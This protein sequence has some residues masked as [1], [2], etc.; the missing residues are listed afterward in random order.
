MSRIIVKNLGKK[1]N[2]SDLKKHFSSK[3]EITDVKVMRKPDGTSRL[4]AFVG[5]RTDEQ[6]LEA[7]KFFDNT[8]IGLSKIT[9]NLAKK[10][11]DTELEE[12]KKVHEKK[13][14]EKLKSIQEKLKRH[15]QEALENSN[16]DYKKKN[17]ISNQKEISTKKAEFLELAVNSSKNKKT[18]ANDDLTATMG[19]EETGK[20]LNKKK[21]SDSDSDSDDYDSDSEDDNVMDEVKDEEDEEEKLKKEKKL[22][23]LDYLRSRMSSQYA[24]SDSDSD[25]ENEKNDNNSDSDSS[26]S[27]NKNNA[28]AFSEKSESEE[29]EDIEEEEKKNNPEEEEVDYSRLYVKNL[30]YS[31][32]EDELRDLCEKFGKVNDVHIPLDNDKRCKGFGYVSFLFPKDS[33]KALRELN[34]GP[35]QGRLLKVSFSKAISQVDKYLINDPAYQKMSSFQKKK[36]EERRKSATNMI[37]ANASYI[38]SDT[39]I[40]SIAEKY[41]VSKSDIMDTSISGGDMAIRMAIAET[42]L[43][44]ENKKFLHSHGINIDILESTHSVDAKKN[45]AVKRSTTLLLIKNLPPES[46]IDELENMFSKFGILD[47]ALISPSKTLAVVEFLE[48]ADAR[49]ALKGLAYKRYKNSP[50]YV[51]FA[52]IDPNIDESKKNKNKGVEDDKKKTKETEKKQTEKKQ[53]DLPNNKEENKAVVEDNMEDY[54]T[55]FVKNLNFKSTEEDLKN[56]L[57]KNGVSQDSLRTILIQ[58]KEKNG[59]LLSQGY[60]FIEFKSFNLAQE[61]LKKLSNTVLDEKVLDFKPSDK[62]L[63]IAPNSLINNELKNHKGKNGKLLVKNIAFQANLNELKKLFSNFGVIK[64]IKLPKKMGADGSSHRGFAFVEFGTN[65]EAANAMASL[66]NTHLYGRHLV[67]E[68]AKEDEENV[69]LASNDTQLGGAGLTDSRKRAQADAEILNVLAKKKGKVADQN[70]LSEGTLGGLGDF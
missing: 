59:V 22:S 9:V 23:D 61:S 62:R 68:W 43:I 25:E 20:L 53:T 6:A 38:R 45:L 49:S 58:K 69:L 31:C 12:S 40:E 5:F 13:S 11:N 2:E 15:E 66:K 54:S 4:F 36:E 34:G 51:E 21:R 67:I 37:N 7:I 17:D 28:D 65:Q 56:H 10:L 41:G 55:L 39:V 26:D 8:F 50:L 27:D 18:W 29:E 47:K 48:A 46:N 63:S 33:E 60:G 19:V 32:T 14:I 30:P 1:I 42:Q 52:P 57:I 64:R 24:F 35:F 70:L 3:G 16:P 44:E